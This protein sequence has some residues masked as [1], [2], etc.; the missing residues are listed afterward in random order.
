M[1][2]RIRIGNDVT[3]T[4]PA[5][6][7][8][9]MFRMGDKRLSSYTYRT[10]NL[11]AWLGASYSA[12]K[13]YTINEVERYFSRDTDPRMSTGVRLFA[14]M[15]RSTDHPDEYHTRPSVDTI[16]DECTVFRNFGQNTDKDEAIGLR[17][18]ISRAATD[19]VSATESAYFDNAV[20]R[21][22]NILWEFSPDGGSSKWYQLYDLPNRKNTRITLP[23]PT[24]R[25]RVRAISNNPSEWVQALAIT[26]HV[27][28]QHDS[29]R[30]FAWVKSGGGL[31]IDGFGYIS[32]SGTSG[33]CGSPI[34]Y[35]YRN[36][37][38]VKT[39]VGSTRDTHWQLT[40]YTSTSSATYSVSAIDASGASI[41][42]S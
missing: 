11:Q 36:L 35:V 41:T 42:T 18:R 21:L 17:F 39:L 33:G 30:T 6:G 8:I 10:W 16:I 24:G 1:T 9:R 2:I 13:T 38:S 14:V 29:S 31:T 28:Y 3:S 32:W 25:I 20:F 15:D 37:D 23:E 26:P 27:D 4:T 34:Y 19:T 22:S 5:K 7:N 40:D 12:S